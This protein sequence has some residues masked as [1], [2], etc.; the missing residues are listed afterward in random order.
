MLHLLK[1][2][3]M[4]IVAAFLL[5]GCKNIQESNFSEAPLDGV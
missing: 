2:K 4:I 5:G 3:Q 1:E